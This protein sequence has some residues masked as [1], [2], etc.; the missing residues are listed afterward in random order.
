MI[1][2][3]EL[4]RSVGL[5]RYLTTS[6]G[7][8]GRLKSYPEDFIVDEVPLAFPPPNAAGKYT[9]AAIRAR[10]WETN[11]LV[12]EIAYRL[13]VSRDSIFF[14][15]TK[16]KRAVTTQY[17]SLR[18]SE[19]AVKALDIRDVEI[20]ETRRVDRAPKIGELVGNRFQIRVRDALPGALENARATLSRLEQEGGFPNYFGIQRFGVIRPITHHVG[21]AILKGNLEEAVRLY[22]GNPVAAESDDA[23]EARA[24]FEK[25]GDAAA[26][27]AHYPRHLSFERMM[28]EHLAERPNDYEGALF[29]LPANLRTMFVYAAQ[30]LLFNRM[31]ARRLAAGVGLNEPTVG[32]IV[33]AVDIDGRPEKERLHEVNERN[34]ERVKKL[35]AEGGALVTGVVFGSDVPLAKGI[36][37][38]IERSVIE[39]AGYKASDFIVPHLPEVASYGTRRELLAPL[40]PV[41]LTQ[42]EDG[43]LELSFFLLK[44]TYATCLLREVMKSEGATMA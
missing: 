18:A 22:V 24:F 1:E 30:S 16:D 5:E 33:V 32:D 11:R 27:I 34:L 7:I 44:G 13:G 19:E 37:G 38:E 17:M 41:K 35:A 23:R 31:I 43:A 29:R 40:G 9:V 8:A 25:T 26:S 28:L 39:E 42:N 3:G 36:M 15:G 10:N 20:L 2:P 21:R 14:A 4:E 6:P 12:Q